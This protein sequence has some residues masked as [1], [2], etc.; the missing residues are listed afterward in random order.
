MG[1][2]ISVVVEIDPEDI[3]EMIYEHPDRFGM[4]TPPF[5]RNAVRA[6][7]QYSAGGQRERSQLKVTLM[8]KRPEQ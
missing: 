2:P 3:L 6:M 5:P 7:I 1:N 4:T 8:P